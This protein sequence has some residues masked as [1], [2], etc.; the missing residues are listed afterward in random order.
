MIRSY[1]F[2]PASDQRKVA[3]AL[4]S[5][6]DAVILDLEDAVPF[7]AKETARA[8]VRPALPE[9]PDRPIFVRI[10]AVP[11]G[12]ARADAEAVFDPRLAG[13]V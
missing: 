11:T 12:L 4:T 13:L 8:A 9:R 5:E 2:A 10:N 1:L 7:A 3:R 6:A